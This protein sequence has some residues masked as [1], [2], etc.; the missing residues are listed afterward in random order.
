MASMLAKM[1]E[2]FRPQSSSELAL[3]VFAAH[4]MQKVFFVSFL[5]KSWKIQPIDLLL[6]QPFYPFMIA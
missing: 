3:L 4:R 2:L 5:S 1:V 6:M